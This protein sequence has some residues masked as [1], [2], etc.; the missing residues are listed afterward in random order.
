MGYT[1][2]DGTK[3]ATSNLSHC[4]VADDVGDPLTLAHDTHEAIGARDLFDRTP[5]EDL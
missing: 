4:A 5:P 3:F 1:I 2:P